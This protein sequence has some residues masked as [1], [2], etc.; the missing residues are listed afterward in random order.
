MR[1]QTDM[2]KVVGLLQ[3]ADTYE[4]EIVHLPDGETV[5]IKDGK[6]AKLYLTTERFDEWSVHKILNKA[7]IPIK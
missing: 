1:P 7:G 6:G 5:L 2:T 3:S 4:L